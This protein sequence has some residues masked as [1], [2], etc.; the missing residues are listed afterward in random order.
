M[1]PQSGLER[2]PPAI[3]CA[4]ACAIAVY[5]PPSPVLRA[6]LVLISA[7]YFSLCVVFLFTKKKPILN[8]GATPGFCAAL[9]CGLLLGCLG[10]YRIESRL[11][12][13]SWGIS[14][15]LVHG[16][17]AE[18]TQDSR[19]T[20]SGIR[21]YSVSLLESFGRDGTRVDAAGP[22]LL[23]IRGGVVNNG[24]VNSDN[25][26]RGSRIRVSARPLEG[27]PVFAAAAD[28][29][30]TG[31]PP[32][33]EAWRFALRSALVESIEKSAGPIA[34]PLVVALL[35]GIRDDLDRETAL[36]FTNAGCA[37][38]LALSGQHLSVLAAILST[39]ISFLLGKRWSRLLAC[40]IIAFYVFIVGAGPSVLRAALMFGIASIAHWTDRPQSALTIL[41]IGFLAAILV[42]PETATSVSF[43]LSYLA[44]AGIAV[45]MP[46]YAFLL[47]RWVPHPIASALGMGFGALAGTAPACFIMFGMFNIFSPLT[48]AIAGPVVELLLVFGAC[49]TALVGL[50]PIAAAA[51]SPVCTILQSLLIGCMKL[52][53]SLPIIKL[54]SLAAKVFAGFVVALGCIIV[55][56]VPYVRYR[57]SSGRIAQPRKLR[58]A[59][60]SRRPPREPGLC[61]A[62]KIRPEFPGKPRSPFA[63]PKSRTAGARAANLGN[64]ARRRRHDLHGAAVGPGALD[65]RD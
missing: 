36:L 29:T 45:F 65:L 25:L 17:S 11:T 59:Q 54:D 32:P 9:V 27:A 5:A 1:M 62:K 21:A 22:V 31:E 43:I 39:I 34:A 64:R 16:F 26:A 48:S 40:V 35:V 61:D 47:L 51:S 2:I 53:A 4:V 42:A 13:P 18:I 28:V 44:V 30:I 63:H 8:S 12:Q 41:A 3:P 7:C 15:K 14:G 20:A 33:I 56:A 23:C 49:A 52:G 60:R 55:Y 24:A 58:L 6:L 50:L 10:Q 38:V 19:T 57:Y 46:V 37:H